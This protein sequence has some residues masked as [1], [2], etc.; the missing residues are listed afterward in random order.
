[1]IL[2]SIS[3]MA[4]SSW[5]ECQ[6][7]EGDIFFYKRIAIV[8]GRVSSAMADNGFSD[9]RMAGAQ[10][11][12]FRDSFTGLPKLPPQQK[13]KHSESKQQNSNSPF[14]FGGARQRY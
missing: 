14:S 6:S 7:R 10:K 5:I 2:Y 1:M 8:G 3:A 13:Q 11:K 9:G 4:A 12:H